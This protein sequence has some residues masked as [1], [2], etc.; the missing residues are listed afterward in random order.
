MKNIFK[1]KEC[2][3]LN[4]CK[5]EL[6]KIINTVNYKNSNFIVQK[7]N[8]GYAIKYTKNETYVDLVSSSH[9]WPIGSKF[10]SECIGDLSTI[11]KVLLTLI[12]SL[13]PVLN[14]VKFIIKGTIKTID[15][16]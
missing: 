10:Q 16:F 14:Q 12:P 1:Y 15:D 11:I 5:K 7:V 3:K 13:T 4:L 8:D 6:I 9:K 2:K